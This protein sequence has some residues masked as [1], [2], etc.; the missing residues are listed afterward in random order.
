MNYLPLPQQLEFAEIFTLL[1]DKEVFQSFD[2]IAEKIDVDPE[3]FEEFITNS[4]KGQQFAAESYFYKQIS[5][6]F[7]EAY[8]LLHTATFANVVS[9]H[10]PEPARMSLSAS[11]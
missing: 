4:Y 5:S 1:V 6:F 3:V 2:E 7:V 8:Q 11:H 9:L 10:K